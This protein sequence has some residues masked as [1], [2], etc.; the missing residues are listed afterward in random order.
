MEISQILIAI[1]VAVVVILPTVIWILRKSLSQSPQDKTFQSFLQLQQ[2]LHNL[3]SG[4]QEQIRSVSGQLAEHMQSNARF[5]QDSQQNYRE[6]MD[7]VQHRLGVLQG[8]TQSM[9]DIGKDISSLQ[10]ILRAPKLRG[11]MGEFL[12]AELLRQILPNDH[13]S[14]QHRFKNGAQV[15]AVI[16][17]GEGLVPVDAK[18]PLENF[19]RILESDPSTEAESRKAF[20]RDIKKHVDDISS[21]YIL[22]EEGTFEFAMMYIPSESIYYETIIRD[23]SQNESVSSYAIRHKVI[24]VSPNSFYAYL[25]AMVRGLKG[26]RIERS[27]QIILENLG[28]LEVSLGQCLSDFEKIGVHLGHARASYEKTELRFRKLQNKL[29]AMG[30]GREASKDSDSRELPIPADETV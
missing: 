25:Q 3:H 23:E 9:V 10:D 11:G 20:W 6:V 13:F 5:L 4:L 14:L 30:D 24:P 17:L 29:S 26:M 27:A 1:L 8:A 12:L 2:E 21:K 7:N 22:P 15:D 16:R 19:T 28:Q 18:F